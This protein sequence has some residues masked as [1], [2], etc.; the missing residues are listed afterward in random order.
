MRR[1]YKDDL[2]F[3]QPGDLET[4]ATPIDFLGLNY[5]FRNIAR[6]DVIAEAENSPHTVVPND[7]F[8]EMGW[9]VYP[10]G[11][12]EMLGH[13]RF[14]HGS[15]SHCITEDGTAVRDQVGLDGQVEDPAR[16]SYLRRHLQQ[17]LEAIAVGGPVRDYFV[18][19]LLDNFEWA[20]G[21]SE[22]FGLIHVDFQ[23]QQRTPKASA[24]WYQQVIGENTLV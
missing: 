18:G 13:L 10:Q 20:Y 2:Q 8:T 15:P 9:E 1:A 16:V 6:S 3:I 7:E 23:T 11:M 24:K 12:N 5:Y 14:G 19:S 17:V 22:R 4:I 21:T